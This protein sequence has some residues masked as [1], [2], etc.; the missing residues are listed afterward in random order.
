MSLLAC[1]LVVCFYA[2]ASFR[3]LRKD[4]AFM[5]ET[6]II[7]ARVENADQCTPVY[8]VVVEWERDRGRVFSIDA[9]RVGRLGVFAFFVKYSANQYVMAF[10][11]RNSNERY[12]PGEPAWIHSD[13][14][15][16][17]L[18]V[19][20][21]PRERKARLSGRLSESTVIPPAVVADVRG[22]RGT[23]A[24]AEAM[25]GWAI[26]IALGDI[27]D[28]EDPRFSAIRGEEGMWRPASF[29]RET[30]AGIYFLE[31]YDPGRVP[32]L[33]VYGIAGSPQDW[34]PFFSMIDR[35][36]YQAWFYLYPTG[37]RLDEM[38]GA[39]N[40]AVD[41]LQAHLGFL[42]LHVVGHSMGGLV[43]K[44]FLI[45][46][47]LDDENRYIDRFVSISTPWGGHEAAAMGVHFSPAVVPSW[48]D[49]VS[50]SEFQKSILSKPLR[51]QVDHLLLYGTRSSFSF[52]LPDENDG[53]VS[54]ASQLAPAA[55]AD[56]VRI[57]GFDADHVGILSLPE[58]V[59]T[60]EAFLGGELD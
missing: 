24:T 13:A 21:D 42:R 59:R 47:V 9:T 55:R 28:P 19:R 23:R 37:R 12:D 25:T 7:S 5:E 48:R 6:S 17:A 38:G 15:G 43:S 20:I 29:P 18:P 11:D 45:K 8:G 31:P 56:A 41:L 33:F 46:N 30:G 4:V 1:L 2:C 60:V 52:V 14:G 36:K 58:V 26:P 34:R 10:S 22:F 51:G 3:A 32:V 57:I 16:T 27:A 53:T 54:V 35:T 39:L 50:G 40:R 44:S 49:M